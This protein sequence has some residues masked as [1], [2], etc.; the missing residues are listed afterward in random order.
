MRS[1]VEFE[2]SH[3][4]S[5]RPYRETSLLVE[6]FTQHHGRVGVVARGVRGPK[7]RQ[8]GVLRCFAPLLLSWFGSGDLVTLI[9]AESAAA[10]PALSGERIFF[11]WYLNELI[12]KLVHRHDAHPKL[13]ERYVEALGSLAGDGAEAALRVF[14][15]HLLAELGYALP[16]NAPIDPGQRY[17]V[18]AD[19]G[20]LAARDEDAFAYPGTSLI[21]LRDESFSGRETLRDALRLLRTAL[22]RQLNG[23][24]LE[25]PRLLRALRQGRVEGP[26]GPARTPAQP[27]PAPEER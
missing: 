25:T 22:A 3:V 26:R 17:R 9:S 18:D 6:A 4:L 21:A 11:G 13:Y 23:R 10:S 5:A 1:R 24:E 20:L 2:P 7:A 8:R 27:D 15:K 16:L 14:E 12:L 19:R